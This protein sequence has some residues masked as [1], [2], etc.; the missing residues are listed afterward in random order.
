MRAKVTAGLA[1]YWS[2]AGKLM[3]S[4]AVE[5]FWLAS[6]CFFFAFVVAVEY[7]ASIFSIIPVW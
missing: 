6:S 4:T 2:A 3:S 7:F 1:G 5:W